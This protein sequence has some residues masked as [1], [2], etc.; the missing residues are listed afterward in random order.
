MNTTFL[1]LASFAQEWSKW[2]FIGLSIGVPLI[3]VAAIITYFQIKH[4]SDENDSQNTTDFEND[5]II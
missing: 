4:S 3:I 5:N 1:L 2:F